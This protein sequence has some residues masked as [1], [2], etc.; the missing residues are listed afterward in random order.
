MNIIEITEI[1]RTDTL[2]HYMRKYEGMLSFYV[3]PTFVNSQLIKFTLEHDAAGRISVDVDF[4]GQID[5]PLIPA[6]RKVKEFILKL[7]KLGEL[8]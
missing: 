8:K 6:Q 2:L 7:D 1:K 5:Y 3:N 4:Q